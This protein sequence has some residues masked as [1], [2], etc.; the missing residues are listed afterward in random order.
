[1][2]I[3]SAVQGAIN[4]AQPIAFAG[5]SNLMR[6]DSPK[7]I[8]A[9]CDF[10]AAGIPTTGYYWNPAYFL[11]AG[12]IKT[13]QCVYIDNSLNNGPVTV[14]N[15][16]FNQSF[17]LSAGWQ[18]YFPCIAPFLSGGNFNIT[19]TGTGI[20]NVQFLNVQMGC[21]QWAATATPVTPGITQPVSDAILDATVVAGRQNVTTK[22]AQLTSVDRSGT[23]AVANTSQQ[24]AAA[25]A[26]RQGLEI[27]NIDGVNLE[28]IW[29]NPSG[30]A[31]VVGG[32]GC[33]ELAAA[34]SPNFP[35][36]FAKIVTSNQVN[37]IA[38]TAGHKFSAIE[39]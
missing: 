24:L 12:Y 4:Q 31:A 5:G 22:F 11:Q 29:Y 35:G 21:A 30:G 28:G 26:A 1:M 39:Y 36:G 9:S 14:S 25:N 3:Y 13:V 32:V 7:S 16:Q 17:T 20:A 23:I 18:G 2:S 15:P 10:S 27:Q 6:N 37:I 8:N 34:S 38:T 33:F 19:S